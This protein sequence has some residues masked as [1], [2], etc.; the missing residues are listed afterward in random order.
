M[1]TFKKD[2]KLGAAVGTALSL[3]SAGAIAGPHGFDLHNVLHGASASFAGTSIA[4]VEDPVSAVFG[5]PA[6]LTTY[7]GGT[8]FMF[9]ATF[10][11]PRATMVHDGSAGF[12][13][14]GHTSLDT[15]VEVGGSSSTEGVS[16]FAFDS[17]SKADVYA[18]PTVAVTQ[19][20]SGLGIPVV[21]GVGVSA[22]SG[23]GVDYKHSS[24][25]LGAA[26]DKLFIDL[27]NYSAS[28]DGYSSLCVQNYD[29]D[30]ELNSLFVLLR[31]LKD[32]YM[33]FTDDDYDML[34][35]TYM[36]T[37]SATITQLMKLKLN[38]QKSSCSNYLKIFERFDRK[39]QKSLE[40]L[41]RMINA[42]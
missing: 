18:V 23:I 41:E 31:E 33:L 26:P 12:A 6:T 42:Y 25:S 16:A 15:L 21:L 38:V 5:N 22:T 4:H 35:S 29:D 9:G 30:Q 32:K 7:Y 39:K 3:G 28:I 8:N 40:D 14:S 24:N 17:T 27:V 19:D 2:W 34:K 11:M 13:V 1:K 36:K 20:L 10:Y 37:K